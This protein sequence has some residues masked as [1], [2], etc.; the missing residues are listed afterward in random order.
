MH[1]GSFVQIENY[2]VLSKSEKS[3]EKDDMPVVL[4]VQFTTSV[5]VIEDSKNEFIPK[6]F[7]TDSISEFRK[8]SHEQWATATIVAY[9]ISIKG[10]YGCFHQ[11]IIANGYNKSN[12]DIVALGPNFKMSTTKLLKASTMANVSCSYSRILA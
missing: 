7:H 11:L 9:V 5:L 2:G 10:T 12:N 1:V 6:F 4:K 3:Y 8:R